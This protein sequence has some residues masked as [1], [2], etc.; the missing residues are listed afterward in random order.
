M[1]LLEDPTGRFVALLPGCCVTGTAA[2]KDSLQ[3][4][5]VK[6]PQI[7]LSVSRL[8][9]QLAACVHKL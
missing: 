3:Q 2:E 7:T 4:P 6:T 5:N 9:S 1:P 8:H